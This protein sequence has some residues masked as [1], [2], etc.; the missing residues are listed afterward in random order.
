MSLDDTK[1]V[2]DIINPTIIAIIPATN[3]RGIMSTSGNF[4]T[5]N[6]KIAKEIGII[7]ATIFPVISPG[8]IEFPNIKIIPKIANKI[9]KNVNLEIVSFK[10]IYPKIAKNNV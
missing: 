8:E 2:G 5:I 4:L 10:K 7:N 6:I 3:W 9:Q 1:I